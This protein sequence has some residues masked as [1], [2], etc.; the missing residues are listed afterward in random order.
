MSYYNFF[1][2]RVRY[3]K[4]LDT[5]VTKSVT[6]PYLVDAFSF[7]EAEA[8]II[9]E[10]S[11]YITG[12]FSIVAIKREKISESF[13]NETG[14]RYFKA[15]LN[16]LTLDEKSG[17]EK[18][19]PATFLVQASDIT[20]AKEIVET[21][22]KGT[23]IDYAFVGILETKIMDVFLYGQSEE[24]YGEEEDKEQQEAD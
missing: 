3:D 24:G 20:E 12:E 7:T 1:E 8:R 22:M 14:D 16:Y 2:C 19:T 21:E 10:I 18:K 17:T 5:G 9:E 11:P 13:F 23:M 15:K 4:T 6:E